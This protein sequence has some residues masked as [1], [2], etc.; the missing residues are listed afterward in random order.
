[1]VILG[2]TD[3]EARGGGKACERRSLPAREV[4]SEDSARERRQRGTEIRD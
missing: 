3:A 4:S 1:M 2:V